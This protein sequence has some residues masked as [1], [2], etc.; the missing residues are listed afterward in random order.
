MKTRK[1]KEKKRNAYH[2]QNLQI[3]ILILKLVYQ[4]QSCVMVATLQTQRS[5]CKD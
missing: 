4:D 5:P 2:I 1:Y 3:G